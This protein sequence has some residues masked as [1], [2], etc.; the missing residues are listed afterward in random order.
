MKAINEERPE[1]RHVEE[2]KLN[3]K[4]VEKPIQKIEKDNQNEQK[5]S[6]LK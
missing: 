5:N 2:Q 1:K 4:A 3:L 6:N